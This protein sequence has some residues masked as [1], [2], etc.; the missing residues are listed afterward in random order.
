M[1]IR[2]EKI[3]TSKNLNPRPLQIKKWICK[4]PQYIFSHLP[5]IILMS[6][7]LQGDGPVNTYFR[8]KF[9]FSCLEGSLIFSM[10]DDVLL[11]NSNLLLQNSFRLGSF[12]NSL[13]VMFKDP[14]GKYAMISEFR[15]R[16]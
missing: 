3:Q 6:R 7:R 12:I 8:V 14:L 13:Q 2:P 11:E 5:L 15:T 9:Q 16:R 10:I 1:K 4:Q